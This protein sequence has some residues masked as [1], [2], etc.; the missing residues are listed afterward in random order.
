MDAHKHS[1]RNLD[2]DL[3]IEARIYALQAGLT[4]GELINLCVEEYLSHC[5]HDDD[6]EE[7]A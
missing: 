5:H 2:R 4:L 1:I 3:I 6:W 7:A